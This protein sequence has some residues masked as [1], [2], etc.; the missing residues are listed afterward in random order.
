MSTLAL[1]VPTTR[2]APLVILRLEG[3]ALLIAGTL[4]Y[5][6]LGGG[7]FAFFGLLLVP[8]LSLLGYLAGPRVGAVVY[9]LGHTLLA[10]ALLAIASLA[11]G[12]TPGLSL[13]LIWVAHIGMDRASGY[14]LKYTSGFHDTHLTPPC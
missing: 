13:A 12:W 10:P 8:D 3:L 11:T 6:A 7:W 2:P 9:N 5:R 4:A 14:G 1:P